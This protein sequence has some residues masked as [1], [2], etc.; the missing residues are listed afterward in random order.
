MGLIS[1]LAAFNVVVNGVADYLR[2]SF[3][4]GHAVPLTLDESSDG[5]T[6]LCATHDARSH[7]DAVKCDRSYFS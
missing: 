3:F 2:E 6:F 5:N 4:D 7:A 1:H